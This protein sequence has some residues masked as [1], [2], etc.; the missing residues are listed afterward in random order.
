MK[1]W[2]I[3]IIAAC[4]VALLIFMTH[5]PKCEHK[6]VGNEPENQIWDRWIT[7]ITGSNI[8][9]SSCSDEEKIVWLSMHPFFL[10]FFAFY[11]FCS[12]GVSGW[13]WSEVN[14]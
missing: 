14:Y 5:P 9:V 3:F 6:Y 4:L 12:V 8:D 2:Q 10:L 7:K 13:I 1:I 11:F